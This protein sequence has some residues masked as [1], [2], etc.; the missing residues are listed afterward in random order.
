MRGLILWLVLAAGLAQAQTR[1]VNPADLELTVTIENAEVTPFQGEMVLVTIHG[2]YRRHITREKLIQPALEGFNWM[3]LGEDHWYETQIRGKKVKNFK[4]R[5]ALFPKQAGKL[6]IDPFVHHLT[7][8]DEGDDWFAHDIRSQP[9]T[10][11]VDPAPQMDGWWLPVRR[12]EISDQWSNAPD[13]LQE[14]EGV[15]RI[16]RVKAVGAS[17]DMIPPMPE[18]TSPSAMIF[19]HPEQRLVELSPQGPVSIAFWRWTI[20]P[21][22]SRSAILEPLTFD[23]FDTTT[24]QAHSATIT[25]QRVAMDEANLPEPAP[26]P[27]PAAQRT[28]LMA[29]TGIIALFIGF[30]ILL[31]G[32]NFSGLKRLQAIP[33]FNPLYRRLRR[34]ARNED[35]AG[36]RRTAVAILQQEGRC[37]ETTNLL[38]QFDNAVFGSIDTA[39]DTLRFA[40]E[41]LLATSN[42]SRKPSGA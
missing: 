28:A 42:R 30:S 13:Q 5:M 2:V 22:R 41:F 23:Y 7:L 10:I 31:L 1:E 9:L 26:P 34:A 36:T 33:A 25:A 39:P 11:N 32:R 14:G 29:G 18:L 4:R 19:P 27:A 20:R 35:L 8:T 38:H 37:P 12:L 24:R 3:Q 15:L 40:R 6:T 16:I 17:P 21:G